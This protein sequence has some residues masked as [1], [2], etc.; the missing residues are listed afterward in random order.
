MASF[1]FMITDSE[2]GVMNTS[3]N[4][5]DQDIKR[6]TN[7]LR[8]VYATDGPAADVYNNLAHNLMDHVLR[9][10]YDEETS[11]AITKFRASNAPLEVKEYGRTK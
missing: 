10:C 4:F 6:I 9:I 8:S 11:Q 7:A 3:F 1:S 2:N 5:T